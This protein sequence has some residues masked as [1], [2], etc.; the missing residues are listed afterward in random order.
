MFYKKLGLPKENEILICTVK[1]ILPHSIFVLLDE[2]KDLE[3][4][5]HISEIAPG[6]IRNIRD[7]VKEDK[8]IVCKV[9]KV[10]K[11]KKH[12]D[13]SLRRVQVTL[14]RKKLQEYKQEQ[15]AEKLLKT[16]AEKLKIS[17]EDLYKKAIN[18]I[19]E[20]YGA[21]TPC[22]KEI[23][24]NKEPL[25]HLKIPIKIS[26]LI[27][28]IVKEKIKLPE[29]KIESILTLKDY[30]SRGI[31]KIKKSIKKAED[32]AKQKKYKIKIIYLGAPKYNLIV[33]SIDYKS[34]EQITKEIADAI[35]Q[36]INKKGGF[37]EWQKKS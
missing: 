37:A 35:T 20:K 25:K 14:K 26:N 24:Y 23:I 36:D 30:T 16:I 15:K 6:R 4:M 7:Y 3:G 18:K 33:N 17:L 32:L 28:K 29:A 1:K 5:I 10:N 27:T 8:K 22:F 9:L 13:L 19:I 31:E 11:E 12:I 34:A 2:Y 21:I